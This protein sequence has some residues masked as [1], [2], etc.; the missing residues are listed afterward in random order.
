MDDT[1]VPCGGCGE[2]ILIRINH[3]RCPGCDVAMHGV[4]GRAAGEEGPRQPR[5]CRNCE[6]S[7]ESEPPQKKQ[8]VSLLFL[9]YFTLAADLH[10]SFVLTFVE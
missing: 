4:C 8:K 3:H 7:V 5:W 9:L 6:S 10:V 2:P 1:T